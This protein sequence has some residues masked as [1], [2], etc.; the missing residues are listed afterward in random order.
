MSETDN[1]RGAKLEVGTLGVVVPLMEGVFS[2][3]AKETSAPLF[4]SPQAVQHMSETSFAERKW[5]YHEAA[6]VAY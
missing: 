2:P 1:M 5:A 3:C 4:G 6:P